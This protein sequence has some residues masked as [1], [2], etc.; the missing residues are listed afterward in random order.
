MTD[1]HDP[2][3]I[4]ADIIY[5]HHFGPLTPE[6]LAQSVSC[7][8]HSEPLCL[9]ESTTIHNVMLELQR[10]GYGCILVTNDAGKLSGLFT[11]RDFLLKVYGTSIDPARTPVW[12]V[13]TKEIVCQPPNV[14]LL[15]VLNLMS[16]G[17]FRHI[18]IVDDEQRPLW[19][20]SV[21]NIMDHIVSCIG[22]AL[23]NFPTD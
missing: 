23:L 12:E 17:G 21:K 14:S 3:H 9:N 7:L 8:P 15:H 19:M 13:M 20:V 11:E 4:A 16:N 1:S 5:Q 22:G 18:P 10:H 2:L 6:F